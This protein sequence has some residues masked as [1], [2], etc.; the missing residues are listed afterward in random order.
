MAF[1]TCTALSQP[2]RSGRHGSLG[3]MTPTSYDLLEGAIAAARAGGAVLVEGLGRPLQVEHKNE[4][5][6]IVTWADLTAHEAIASVLGERFPEHAILGEEGGV[7]V[8]EA[9]ATWLVDPLDG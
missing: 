1:S 7:E 8:G 2:R 5:T 6:S 9:A 4:R 3:S